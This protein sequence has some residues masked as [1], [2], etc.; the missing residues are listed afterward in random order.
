ML[1]LVIVLAGLAI[2]AYR[3]QQAPGNLYV[4]TQVFAGCPKRPSCVSSV[5]H[6]DRHRVP[7]LGYTGDPYTALLMLREV[8]GRMQGQIVDESPEYLHA[9]FVT[10]PLNLRDDLELL[11][12]PGGSIEVRSASRVRWNDLG[13][14]RARV[15][16]LRRAFEATP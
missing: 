15:E 10:E 13:A 8:V 4:E 14:N 12:L 3:N 9:V 11:V 6:D 5:A 2:G 7:V 1:L 16:A